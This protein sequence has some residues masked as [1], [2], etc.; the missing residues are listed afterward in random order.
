MKTYIV[1]YKVAWNN[2]DFTEHTMEVLAAH[3]TFA[4]NILHTIM[5]EED[6]YYVIISIALKGK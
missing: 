3:E 4:E 6:A 2:K 1:R 5:L